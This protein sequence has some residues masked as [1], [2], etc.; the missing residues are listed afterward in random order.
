CD[1]ADRPSNHVADEDRNDPDLDVEERDHAV[2]DDC[3]GDRRDEPQ[4]KRLCEHLWRARFGDGGFYTRFT[5]CAKRLPAELIVA[6]RDRLL[7]RRTDDAG[8]LIVAA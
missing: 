3:P 4:S 7:A 1:F 6:V 8:G 5:G 2:V